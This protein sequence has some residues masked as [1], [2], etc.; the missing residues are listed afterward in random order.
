MDLNAQKRAPIYEA[1]EA[2]RRKRI[3]PFDEIP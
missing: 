2:F 3:V 1:L